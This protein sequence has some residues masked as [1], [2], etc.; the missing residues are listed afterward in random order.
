MMKFM[1]LVV[2]LVPIMLSGCLGIDNER[3]G[4][5]DRAST[6]VPTSTPT[7][8]GDS[9]VQIQAMPNNPDIVSDTIAKP[10]ITSATNQ[11]Q[12][13]KSL[14]MYPAKIVLG[15]IRA[16]V[17]VDTLT[18]TEVNADY[19]DYIS[20]AGDPVTVN[21]HNPS[22]GG[23]AIGLTYEIMTGLTNDSDT[24]IEYSPAPKIVQNWVNI[25]VDRMLIPPNSIA[26]IPIR[27]VIPKDIG[28]IKLPVH[29]EFRIRVKN[30]DQIGM[31]QTETLQR[32]L[33]T[34]KQ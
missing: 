29:W 11:A 19:P 1:L 5:S 8:F 30:I 9:S 23:V 7:R 16:G 2:I 34:M 24:G 12:D 22:W 28:N 6:N 32:W 15:N 33:I 26:H 27:L 10:W 3:V 4:G 21:I 25:S 14:P 18:Q 31:F 13:I 20:K 17:I